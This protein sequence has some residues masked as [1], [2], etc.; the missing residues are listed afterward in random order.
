[1]DETIDLHIHTNFSDGTKS[2]SEVLDIVREKKLAA[3]SVCDHD[4]I[5]GYKELKASL[6]ADDPELVP[7]VELSAGQKNEDIHILGYYFDTESDLLMASLEVFR[8]KRNRRGMEMLKKMEGLGIKLSYDELKKIAGHSAIGRPNVADALHQAGHVGSFEEAFVRYI[9]YHGPAYV[10]KDNI[11]PAEAIELIHKA[12]GLAILAHPG[13]AKAGKHIEEFIRYGLDGIEAIHPNHNQRLQ[14]SYLKFAE[15]NGLLAT[16]GSDYHGRGGRY[17]DI[18]S[19]SVSAE[20]WRKL[21]EKHLSELR[22]QN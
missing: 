8:D 19:M 3:F 11:T 16:G 17:G 4:N 5:D 13:I 14:Q 21:K 10:H 2:P 18:D 7:G 22:G 1:M 20:L 12:N 9:G 15:K 6:T